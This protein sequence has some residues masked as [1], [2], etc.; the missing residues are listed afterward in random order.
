[1]CVSIQRSKSIE[2]WRKHWIRVYG[3][4]FWFETWS[5]KKTVCN[6]C[7]S[8]TPKSAS[9]FSAI[10]FIKRVD[11]GRITTVKDLESWRFERLINSP[12]SSVS[13]SH[14]RSTTVSL[15]TKILFTVHVC[16]AVFFVTFRFK[17][18]FGLASFAKIAW[19]SLRHPLVAKIALV[20]VWR[21][22]VNREPNSICTCSRDSAVMIL[23]KYSF[24]ATPRAPGIMPTRKFPFKYK[25][26]LL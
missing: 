13:I 15:E 6:D 26:A 5:W 17:L 16:F 9:T 22:S 19:H 14:R 11:K 18:A 4:L 2:L 25:F 23:M 12:P 21:Y 24:A 1:M 8:I 7:L 10:D 3:P 20:G